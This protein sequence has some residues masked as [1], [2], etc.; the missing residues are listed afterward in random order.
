[1]EREKGSPRNEDPTTLMMDESSY[2]ELTT[3]FK[4]FFGKLCLEIV[5]PVHIAAL[6][7]KKKLISDSIIQDMLQCSESQVAK[8]V[9][10]MLGLLR[11]VQS[12]PECIVV[13]I[14]VLSECRGMQIICYEMLREAGIVCPS[15]ILKGQLYT[16]VSTNEIIQVASNKSEVSPTQAT[17]VSSHCDIMSK[18]NLSPVLQKYKDYLS[19]YYKARGLA[20]ADKYLPALKIPYI[21][22]AIVT[23]ESYNPQQRDEFTEQTLQGGV[24]QILYIKQPVVIEDLMKPVKRKP[25]KFVLVEG[26]PGIG[27]SAFAWEMCRKWENIHSLRA[28]QLVVLLKLR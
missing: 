8:T 16:K 19:S 13:F 1:M 24:D 10:L 4:S 17:S 27:K 28:Y 20:A 23:S 12:H 2:E 6:M 7:L 21:N 15:V 14:E 26:A 3:V 18:H 22:L 9:A 11:K 25:V 5:D